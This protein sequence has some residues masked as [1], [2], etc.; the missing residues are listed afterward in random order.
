VSDAPRRLRIVWNVN[1]GR[2]GGL[3]TSRTGEDQLRDIMA[4]H[5]LGEELVAS[6]S[7]ETAKRAS[8]DARSQ[9]YDAVVAAGG[10]GTVGLVADILIGSSTALGILPMGTVMNICRMLGLPRDLDEAARV[11]A[12]G[13]TR[14]IDVGVVQDRPFYE[15][16]SVGINAAIF[17]EIQRAD[18]G[19]IAGLARAIFAAFRYRPGRMT[20]SMDDQEIGTRALMVSVSN[21]PYLGAGFTVAPGAR[22]DDGLFDVRV[23]RHFSKLDLARHFLAI[24]LGRRAYSPHA[25]TYRSARVRIEGARPLPARADS[26][27]LGTTPVEFVVRPRVLEVLVQ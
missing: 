14:A 1:S 4:R 24:A 3:P 27:D 2:K 10:D 21:G 5:G 11:V 17:R 8:H 19:D 6:D 25:S 9:G 16:G 7:E 22:L 20:I 15:A 13:R 18:E 12:A 23:F 26:R